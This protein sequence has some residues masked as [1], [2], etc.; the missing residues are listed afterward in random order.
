MEQRRRR[1]VRR[2]SFISMERVREG[3]E[4]NIK[5][6]TSKRERHELTRNLGQSEGRRAELALHEMDSACGDCLGSGLGRCGGEWGGGRWGEGFGGD[7][8]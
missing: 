2:F 8:L 4:R 6:Q 5:H 3:R 1:S 7:V